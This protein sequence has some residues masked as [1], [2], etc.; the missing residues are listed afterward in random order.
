[1]NTLL[2][3]LYSTIPNTTIIL[4]TLLPNKKQPDR[5]QQISTQY[6]D[7]VALRRAQNDR[8]VLADMSSFIKVDQL[9]DGTHPDDEGYR[10]MAAVWW[11]AIQEAEKAGFIQYAANTGTN[12]LV[13]ENVEVELDGGDS[14]SDPDL[15]GYTASAAPAAPAAQTGAL[16]VT[17][18]GNGR[19][20]DGMRG[21]GLQVVAGK[22]VW[23]W[24]WI[25]HVKLV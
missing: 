15:P 4:S 12:G 1:M 20:R 25:F 21:V 16:S 24:L 14:I 10:E 11:T 9:V 19:G 6:R 13:S 23:C 17:G 3:T 7:L 8:I 18:S 5:I 22:C 2:T